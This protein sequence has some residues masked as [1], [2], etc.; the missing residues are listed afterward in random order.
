M[1]Q[2]EKTQFTDWQESANA[3]LTYL[4]IGVSDFSEDGQVRFRASYEPKPDEF[5]SGTEGSITEEFLLNSKSGWI[6]ISRK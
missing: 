4:H 5:S 3:V 6:E 2:L 1:T